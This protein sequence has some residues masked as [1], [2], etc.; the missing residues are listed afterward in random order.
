M[1]DRF[2]ITTEH[3]SLSLF[4]AC[5]DAWS[6]RK[7]LLQPKWPEAARETRFACQVSV[8]SLRSSGDSVI[9]LEK[10]FHSNKSHYPEQTAKDVSSILP[11]LFSK[12]QRQTLEQA[13]NQST[14]LCS[15]AM[16]HRCLSDADYWHNVSSNPP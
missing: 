14:W 10:F 12:D 2:H 8:Q 16:G 7:V 5:L 6:S 15:G 13:A 4:A 3:F 9:G 1:N 11:D